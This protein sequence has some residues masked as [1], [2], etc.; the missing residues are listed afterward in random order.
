MRGE[1]GRE[2]T[3]YT[4]DFNGFTVDVSMLELS[5]GEVHAMVS[6][7][8]ES[9]ML[10]ASITPGRSNLSGNRGRTDLVRYLNARSDAVAWEDV[11][12]EV[13]RLVLEAVKEGQPSVRITDVPV[14]PAEVA[15]RI[16][17]LVVEGFPN[18]IF[19]PGGS[20]KSLCAI[21]C[22]CAVQ[23]GWNLC[24]FDVVPGGVYVC[25]WELDDRTYRRLADQLCTG[26]GIELP[27]FH[28][29][30]CMGSL[31]DEAES[32]A[33][34]AAREAIDL[35]IV[36][37]L[38]FAVGG[39]K[40]S[41]ETTMRMFSA[42]RT[43]RRRDGSQI[44]VLAVDHVTNDDTQANRP[45]G[46][47]YTQNAARSLWRVRSEQEEG[48]NILELGLFQTKANFGKQAPIGLKA[49][50]S[51]NAIYVT[52]ADVRQMGAGVKGGLSASMKIKTCLVEAREPL[53]KDTIVE[54]TG[55]K[56]SIVKAR[57]SD[58]EKRGDLVRMTHPQGASMWALRSHAD[59][60]TS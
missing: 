23:G 19:G 16:A 18:I 30:Q 8:S 51:E 42:M 4:I 52:R 6:V 21:L 41:Q 58:L 20:G 37:S 48:S 50:F 9:P 36:D 7:A 5:R 34:Y 60:A 43:W 59:E 14:Q 3:G 28:Y 17:P 33:R 44:T 54:R 12:E 11:V 47:V 38:G 15:F 40:A 49:E 56:E 1:L 10:P 2:G 53:N 39:D 45:Y 27:P 32:I 55:L 24:D 22:A 13:C 35:I 31:A 57:L 29:R 26:F 25:D 46:S